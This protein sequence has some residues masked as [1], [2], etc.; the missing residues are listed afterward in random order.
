LFFD[1]SEKR[2][3]TAGEGNKR[4][5]RFFALVSWFDELTTSR[6]EGLTTSLGLKNDILC[7]SH[8]GC[9]PPVASVI[10]EEPAE[11][12]GRVS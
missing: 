11:G 7:W 10:L 9:S 2:V 6:F 4:R 3:L 1:G 12:R 5:E 8:S